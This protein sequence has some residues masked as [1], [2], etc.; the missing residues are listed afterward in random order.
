MAARRRQVR[1]GSAD[2]AHLRSLDAKA[3]LPRRSLR[4]RGLPVTLPW[5]CSF[6]V[7]A[8]PALTVL[9]VLDA[10]AECPQ[11]L[12]AK[13]V[14]S[15]EVLV[16]AGAFALRKQRLRRRWQIRGRLGALA[17]RQPEHAVHVEQQAERAPLRRVIAGRG[18]ADRGLRLRERG[19]RIEVI[20]DRCR[21]G[22]TD[23]VVHCSGRRA[24]AGRLPCLADHATPFLETAL[25]G[26]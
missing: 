26:I 1:L 10:Y 3:A 24:S 9:G 8:L 2:S 18:M 21:E 16:R 7:V 17:Q 14:G 13:L 25:G 22:D 23:R 12:V 19:G 11:Q 20:G 4:S 15:F 5:S 6:A